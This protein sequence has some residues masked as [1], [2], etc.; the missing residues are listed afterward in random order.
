M[1]PHPTREARLEHG[2]RYLIEMGSRGA[3][4]RKTTSANDGLRGC[5]VQTLVDCGQAEWIEAGARAIATERAAQ[6]LLEG[7]HPSSRSLVEDVMAHHT[8]LTLLEALGH[9]LAAGGI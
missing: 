5:D 3:A 7:L 1:M 9:L 6:V 4:I 8:T 2:R